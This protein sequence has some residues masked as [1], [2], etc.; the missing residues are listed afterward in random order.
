MDLLELFLGW[1]TFPEV[2]VHLL[3]LRRERISSQT[4]ETVHEVHI[5][6]QVRAWHQVCNS[7]VSSRI[8]ICQEI[9]LE[10]PSFLVI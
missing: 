7:G 4:P 9:G 6:V 8:S 3:L 2:I 1:E 5:V 10:S